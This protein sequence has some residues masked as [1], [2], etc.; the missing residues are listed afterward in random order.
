MRP[1]RSITK[2]RVEWLLPQRIPARDYTL[3][4]GRGKQGKSMW[5][6]AAGAKV[7]T[8]G[9]W[10]DGSGVA[11]RGHVLYL[12]AEDDPERI[13][14]PRLEA[15]GA[16]LDNITVLEARFKLPSSDGK[17]KL[18][19]FATLQDLDY[20][21]AV[22]GRIKNP[23]MLVVDPLPSYLG[24]GV[25][26]RRNSDVRAILGPFVE[27]VKE[28]GMT[29]VGVTHFGKGVDG[30]NAVDKVLDSIAY[31]NLARATH[32]IARDPDNP[33]RVLFMPGPCNYARPD[34]PSLAFRLVERT[35]PDGD[36]GEITIAVPEFDPAPVDVDAD[37]V[38]NR[39]SKVRSGTR[40]PDPVRTNELAIALVEFLNGKGPVF[41]GELFDEFGSKGFLGENKW[42]PKE[43]RHEWTNK[44]AL[45]RAADA[46]ATLGPPHNGWMVATSKDDA[47]LRSIS[48]KVR[49][50]V[51]KRES[52][53]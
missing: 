14:V 2:R 28:F 40:G 49:W 17:T 19:S 8:G 6:M 51:R 45:Y 43:D 26:D 18:V 10:W 12:S 1:A 31:V 47:S 37:D 44:K 41:L 22:F 23:V 34:V 25:N 48:G 4:A 16:D 27:L 9:D 46:V 24:R 52:A 38:V 15:L 3:I 5:T 33:E 20:W 50:A 35:I 42:N 30:R 36:G 11:P 53:Y 7:S 21:R 39:Q 32:F 13:I 29:L